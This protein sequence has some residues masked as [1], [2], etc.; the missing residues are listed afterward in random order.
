MGTRDRD[1][2]R[3]RTDRQKDRQR[4]TKI[5]FQAIHLCLSKLFCIFHHLFLFTDD[6]KYTQCTWAPVLDLDAAPSLRAAAAGS[7]GSGVGAI[8]NGFVPQQK[9]PVPG[10]G[11]GG[12]GSGAGDG[13]GNGRTALLVGPSG[14]HKCVCAPGLA[15]LRRMSVRVN[16]WCRCL[17]LV[18]RLL[19]F[20]YLR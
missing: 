19:M 10:V 1:S 13:G 11:G 17:G 6:V 14:A 5:K 18:F 3:K 9:L 15:R 16:R 20:R 4:L 8:G 12:G 2:N 7:V